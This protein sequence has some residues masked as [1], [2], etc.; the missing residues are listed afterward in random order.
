[1]KEQVDNIALEIDKAIKDAID[2]KAIGNEAWS[3]AQKPIQIDETTNTWLYI[4][5]KKITITPLLLKYGKASFNLGI[6][7]YVNNTIGQDEKT[8]N[9]SELPKL[10]IVEEIPDNFNIV[11]SAVADYD[12]IT[13]ILKQQFQNRTFDYED[14]KVK[15]TAIDF[16][17]GA[18]KVIIKVGINAD[19]KKGIL[20]KNV[21]GFLF[22]EGTPY[23]D[24]ES[25]SI[26]I[27]DL[28]YNLDTKDVLIKSAKWLADNKIK[29]MME[30]N[31]VF[32]VGDQIQTAKLMIEKELTEYNVNEYATITGKLNDLKPEGIYLTENAI[33]V[34]IL[35]DGKINMTVSGF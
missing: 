16:T 23:Y 30:E 29:A 26:K 35:A 17:G 9:T 32:P 2:L 12:K 22:L 15:I 10:K 13:A 33:R 27:K 20:K 24:A 1:L 4:N 19:F 18:D 6:E 34:V 21:I 31:L 3:M 28:K 8:I 11:L 14:Q 5:P 7:T 25:Q